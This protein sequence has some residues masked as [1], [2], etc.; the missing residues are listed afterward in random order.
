MANST[1]APPLASA[2]TETPTAETLLTKPFW[3]I[4][5]AIIG[6]AVLEILL[7]QRGYFFLTWDCFTRTLISLRWS[8]APFFTLPDLVWLPFQF[9]VQGA[10]FALTKHIWPSDPA[11]TPILLNLM[12]STLVAWPLFRLTEHLFNRRVATVATI[13]YLFFPWGIWTAASGLSESI[14]YFFAVFACWKL[15]LWRDG[16]NARHALMAMVSFSVLTMMRYEGWLFSALAGL[17]FGAVCLR[18]YFSK[19]GLRP[20]WQQLTLL[21]VLA[22]FPLVWFSLNAIQYGNP[23][24]FVKA[25]A[26]IFSAAYGAN[27]WDFWTRAHYYPGYL[28]QTSPF[29]TLLAPLA[30]FIGLKQN[31][32]G[33]V[34]GLLAVVQFGLLYAMS[35]GSSALGGFPERFLALNLI[36][37]LPF[38]AL[39]FVDGV[40]RFSPAITI[41]LVTGYVLY[42]SSQVLNHFPYEW[43]YADDTLETG[44]TLGQLLAG[45]PNQRILLLDDTTD[46]TMAIP[47]ISGQFERFST[48]R[49]FGLS[50]MTPTEGG[51]LDAKEGQAFI[52]MLAGLSHAELQSFFKEKGFVGALTNRP[53]AYLT[54]KDTLQVTHVIGRYYLLTPDATP[55]EPSS[56]EYHSSH[57]DAPLLPMA[58]NGLVA[59]EAIPDQMVKGDFAEIRRTIHPQ[60]EAR[61]LKMQIRSFYGHGFNLGNLEQQIL[62]NGKIVY[63]RDIA[64]VNAWQTFQYPLQSNSPPLDLVVRVVANGDVQ[65]WGWGRASTTLVKDL[66]IQ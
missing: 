46:S 27:S 17:Y 14:Y 34:L 40:K 47:I 50:R 11:L 6:R 39:L 61:A 64:E 53:L 18:A 32:S 58:S 31:R 41:A 51:R 60:P 21:G 26:Q 20:A 36:I 59:F 16:F 9:W 29:L 57:A 30:L 13:L 5:A 8:D 45:A 22:L 52:D 15:V 65:P 62:V 1:D 48:E 12:F 55:V 33:L 7:F 2:N 35:L 49:D 56:W 10:A 3:L 43:N 42:S 44:R 54:L 19:S 24:N 37:L 66:L 63:R 38:V 4:T 28:F 25:S 23:F